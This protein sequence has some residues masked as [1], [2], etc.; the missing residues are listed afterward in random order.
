MSEETT[1]ICSAC[2]DVAAHY[3]DNVFWPTTENEL[4]GADH[5]NFRGDSGNWLW[6][7]SD[8][9]NSITTEQ[10]MELL[11]AKLGKQD[12]MLAVYELDRYGYAVGLVNKEPTIGSPL[13]VYGGG[14]STAASKP[15]DV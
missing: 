10:V 3:L 14:E 2:V 5:Y 1:E 8:L 13:I 6:L 11:A 7:F 4:D 9:L 15:K 12:K